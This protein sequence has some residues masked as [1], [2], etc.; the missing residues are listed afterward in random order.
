[1]IQHVPQFI[2]GAKPTWFFRFDAKGDYRFQTP[3][4]PNIFHRFMQR[5]VLGIYWE[6]LP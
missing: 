4:P 5:L 1:M 2:G 6:K 3:H